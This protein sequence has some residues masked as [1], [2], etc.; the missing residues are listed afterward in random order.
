VALDT[1]RDRALIGI[2]NIIRGNTYSSKAGHKQAAELLEHHLGIFGTDIANDNLLSETATLR[3]IVN[4][5]ATKPDLA[6][7]LTLL[8]LDY[9][10]T[11]L[12][13]AN[14]QFETTYLARSKEQGSASPD[15]IRAKR[16]ETNQLYYDLRDE[17]EAWNTIKK[18][19]EPYGSTIQSVNGVIN[20]Y[21]DLLARRGAG[22]PGYTGEATAPA[23]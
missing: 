14:N 23:A 13:T 4:D 1:L 5:W 20:N 15:T 16:L 7:A 8:D 6:A 17:I 9:W 10:K 11:D 21:N 19:A 12:D 3:N 2:T 18:G 22:K